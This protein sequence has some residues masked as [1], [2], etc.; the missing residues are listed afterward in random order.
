ML[1]PRYDKR[2]FASDIKNL[3]INHAVQTKSFYAQ[4]VQDRA[5]GNLHPG[6][7]KLFRNAYSGGEP[8]PRAVYRQISETLICAGCRH[9]LYLG[10]GRSEEGSLTITPIPAQKSKWENTVGIPLPGIKA[11][12]VSPE[13]L[14]DIPLRAGTRGEI[15]VS[16]PVMPINHCYLGAHNQGGI[17]D[18][19]IV[20]T[21]GTRWARPRDIAEYVILPD[22]QYSYSLRFGP[23]R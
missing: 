11:K 6:D 4:L 10:Y 17:S 7:F 20:D 1:E 19:S 16:T 2:L 23:R 3:H 13:T 5:D 21:E 14:E 15:L 8:I 18:G 22:G 9:P 12:L